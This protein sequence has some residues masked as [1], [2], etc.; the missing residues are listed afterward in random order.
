MKIIYSDKISLTSF[1]VM[2]ALVFCLA[3]CVNSADIV[4][5][6]YWRRS[7]V[8][9]G[10][11]ALQGKLEPIVDIESFNE[12]DDK[13]NASKGKNKKHQQ[14]SKQ[15]PL[16]QDF[17]SFD[18]SIDKQK[19][20][21]YYHGTKAGPKFKPLYATIKESIKQDIWEDIQAVKNKKEGD[22]AEWPK[23][24]TFRI[25]PKDRMLCRKTEDRPKFEPQYIGVISER[26]EPKLAQ[27]GSEKHCMAFI[28]PNEDELFKIL[29]YG[30]SGNPKLGNIQSGSENNMEN[31]KRDKETSTYQQSSANEAVRKQASVSKPY[32][33]NAKEKKAENPI[34]R[35]TNDV[36]KKNPPSGFI[37]PSQNKQKSQLP[38]QKAQLSKDG[39]QTSPESKEYSRNL[40]TNKA[41]Q[42]A[43]AKNQGV[44]LR[45]SAN[46][47]NQQLNRNDLRSGSVE[48]KQK[49]KQFGDPRRPV[50]IDLTDFD[51]SPIKE[52]KE[53]IDYQD[54]DEVESLLSSMEKS[55]HTQNEE[56]EEL[57][58]NNYDPSDN[59]QNHPADSSMLLSDENSQQEDESDDEDD[60]LGDSLKNTKLI[61]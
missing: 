11:N 59:S 19:K 61:I 51:E 54:D 28:L 42:Y 25:Q 49:T 55:N 37:S 32:D 53:E 29:N 50:N 33:T 27:Q 57:S 41:G 38:G 58:A 18:L 13:L 3:N 35:K 12:A 1:K 5:R 31:G 21:A 8:E 20:T 43:K 24:M 60:N 39:K 15:S 44:N 34:G 47:K 56:D 22:C 46:N 7:M 6:C 2:L 40:I 16:A 10:N 4:Y 17:V 52:N 45:S 30:R 23:Y 36:S 14:E 48:D 9:G 26:I